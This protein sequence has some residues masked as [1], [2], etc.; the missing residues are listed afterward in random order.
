VREDTNQHPFL[1]HARS[2]CTAFFSFPFW[3]ISI[4]RPSKTWQQLII[5]TTWLKAAQFETIELKTKHPATYYT[6]ND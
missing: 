4:C 1:I 3:L 6:S 2:D 5:Q